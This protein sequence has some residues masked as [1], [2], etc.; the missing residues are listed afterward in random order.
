[1][2]G[3]TSGA[4]A[5]V[6]RGGLCPQQLTHLKVPTAQ[7]PAPQAICKQKRDLGSNKY[8]LSIYW[9]LGAIRGTW[10][11]AGKVIKQRTVAATQA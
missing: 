9:E 5:G 3:K 2:G 8:L 7:V 11:M 10:H 1:M 6:R 4:S